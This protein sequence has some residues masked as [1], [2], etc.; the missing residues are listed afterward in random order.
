MFDIYAWICMYPF[1][2]CCF[3][4]TCFIYINTIVLQISFFSQYYITL[5]IPSWFLLQYVCPLYF[6]PFPK[7]NILVTFSSLLSQQHCKKHFGT[8]P[9]K[10][11]IETK[12]FLWGYISRSG[13]FGSGSIQIHYFTKYWQIAFWIDCTSFHFLR[14]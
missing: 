6:I 3:E 10:N 13:I 7:I 5:C 4:C 1:I 8:C 12:E 14:Y 11:Q 9:D 2:L